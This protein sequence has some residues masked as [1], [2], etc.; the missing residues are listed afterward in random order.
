MSQNNRINPEVLQKICPDILNRADVGAV[1]PVDLVRK[2]LFPGRHQER[3]ALAC[4]GHIDAGARPGVST[5]D[6]ARTRQLEKENAELRRAN[7]RLAAGAE[8]GWNSCWKKYALIRH[9]FRKA[10]R[11]I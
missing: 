2:R 1:S 9:G 5:V 10:D 6:A 4:V 3:T 8:G 7:A 11:M